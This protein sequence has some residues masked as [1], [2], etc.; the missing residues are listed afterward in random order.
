MAIETIDYFTR[1]GSDV[2]VFTMDMSKAF[3]KVRQSLLF[4]KL[5]SKGLPEIYS[6][7]LIVMYRGQS[8][9]VRWNNTFSKQFPLSNG[10]KQDGNT[11][12]LSCW[13]GGKK[14]WITGK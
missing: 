6:C 3:D 5:V 12:L 13:N 4:K 11:V 1:N 2:Y 8:A 10:G 7:L 9:N 14:H